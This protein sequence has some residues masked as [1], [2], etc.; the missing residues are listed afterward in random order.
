MLGSHRLSAI[1][2]VQVSRQSGTVRV[3][4]CRCTG[5]LY[6]QNLSWFLIS[7]YMKNMKYKDGWKFI[8]VDVCQKLS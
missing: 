5:L 1:I 3:Q 7:D 4:L 6:F 8:E 2:E